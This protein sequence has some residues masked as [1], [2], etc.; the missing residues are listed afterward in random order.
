MQ[1]SELHD[2]E[3]LAFRLNAL[4]YDFPNNADRCVQRISTRKSRLVHWA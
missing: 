3:S 2:F 1:K 4:Q